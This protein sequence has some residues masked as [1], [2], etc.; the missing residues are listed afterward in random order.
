MTP[1]HLHRRRRRLM[2]W[3][4]NAQIDTPRVKEDADSPSS[5]PIPGTQ[6]ERLP[7]PAAGGETAQ[8]RSL[9]LSSSPPSTSPIAAS[10]KS[11]TLAFNSSVLLELTKHVESSI[12]SRM[13]TFPDSRLILRTMAICGGSHCKRV[14]FCAR[15]IVSGLFGEPLRC[16]NLY[17]TSCEAEEEELKDIYLVCRLAWHSTS[18]ISAFT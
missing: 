10:I 17:E 2:T 6:V 16:S 18:T 4:P 7:R 15:G 8:S 1:H 5:L 3:Q 9:S 13:Y 11:L 14:P 12:S